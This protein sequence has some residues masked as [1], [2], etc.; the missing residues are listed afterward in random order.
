MPEAIT[1]MKR[2]LILLIFLLLLVFYVA[3]PAWSL[4]QVR[5][6]IRRDDEALFASKVDFAGVRASLRPVLTEEARKALERAQSSAGGFGALLGQL[7]GDVL[8]RV[9]DAA[10]EAVVTPETV[11]QIAR[12]RQALREAL[13]QVMAEQ[14]S[15]GGLIGSRRKP[16]NTEKPADNSAGQ[17]APAPSGPAHHVPER[18]YGLANIKSF[19]PIGPLAFDIGVNRNADAAEPEVTVRMAFTGSDWKIVGLVP[20][21]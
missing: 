6:A 2:L 10:L 7:Q 1:T 11:M 14:V 9:V 4:F 8:P 16:G 13:R 12:N 20:H 19:A 21:F 17:P 18:R 15:L 5:E 3:W